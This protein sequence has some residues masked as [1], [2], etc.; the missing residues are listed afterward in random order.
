M[1]CQQNYLTKKGE[2]EGR[3]GGEGGGRR[4]EGEGRERSF[5]EIERMLGVS[6]E[7]GKGPVD[8][9]KVK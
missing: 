8:E 3:R 7:K 4:R 9:H 5:L 1:C 2:R 6:T